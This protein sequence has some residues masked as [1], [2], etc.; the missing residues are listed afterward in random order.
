MYSQRGMELTTYYTHARSHVGEEGGCRRW[1]DGGCT[2]PQ[3]QGATAATF[4]HTPTSVTWSRAGLPRSPAASGLGFGADRRPL[5]GR[6][7]RAPAVR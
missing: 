7:V 2:P 6:P 4:I 1:S 3:P 5:H